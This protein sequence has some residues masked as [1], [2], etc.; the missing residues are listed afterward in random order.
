MKKFTHIVLKNYRLILVLI[1]L[2]TLA[3]LYSIKQNFALETDLET[4]MPKSHPAFIFSDKAE[5]QFDIRDAIL[6]AFS[7]SSGIYNESTFKKIKALTKAIQKLEVVEDRD[8][9]LSLY[10]ADNIKGEDSGLEIEPFFKRIPKTETHFS[11]IAANVRSNE[12]VYKRLVSE[13]EKSTLIFTKIKDNSFSEELYEEIL[14]LANS[15]KGDGLEVYVAGQPIVEGTMAILMPKDM[16][17]MFPLVL[18]LIFIVLFVVLKSFKASVISMLVVILSSI[19][20]FG[21][22]LGVGIPIYAPSSLIPVMLIAIGVA[23]AIHMFSHL[24]LQN[25]LHKNWS[26]EALI[27]NM[28]TEMFSPVLMTSVTTAVGFLSLLSSDIIPIKYFAAFT[29]FGVIIAMVFSF[30]LI[31]AALNLVGIPKSKATAKTADTKF[32]IKSKRLALRLVTY[33]KSVFAVTVIVLLFFGFGMS[34]VWINSSFLARFPDS[35]P[36]VTTDAFVNEHFLGTT[37]INVILESDEPGKFKTAEVLNLLD[38]LAM[39][40][41]R[42]NDNVGGSISL[43]DFIKRMN[44]VLN[45]DRETFYTIPEDSDLIAQYI[46]LYEMSGGSDKLWEVVNEDFTTAN[47]QIQLKNDNSKSLNATLNSVELYRSKFEEL[48]VNINFAGS[49]YK[50]LVFN[51]LILQGQI[52]SLLYSFLIVIVLLTLMFRSIKLG[53]IATIPIFIT[54]VISFGV[55]GWLNIPLETTTALI[56]SIAIGIGIDYAVHFIDRYKIEALKHKDKSFAIQETMAHSGRAISFNAI[57]VV[58]GFLVLTLSAFKPNIALGALISLNM[59]TSFIATITIMFI[60]LYAS[61][62]FFNKKK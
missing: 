48:D 53:L 20:T 5:E 14:T 43:V 47:L 44:K 45:E 9:V 24:Q 23:D 37:T 19:W 59:F 54:T 3:N 22:M 51:D 32:S 34:K 33:K 17:K 52:R 56:S 27:V 29:A 39:D 42:D 49:G 55:L 25:K 38:D 11:Q 62:L 6:I 8:D 7:D 18:L 41:V 36:L 10:T 28:N 12:M 1:V 21:L 15:Y 57:V 60:V 61:N 30:V 2:G 35:N 46:L 50:V 16:K 26:K 13:D 58:I 4:Y 31:P 40:V